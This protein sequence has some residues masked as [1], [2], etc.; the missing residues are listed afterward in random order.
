MKLHLP[1]LA[2]ALLTVSFATAGEAKPTGDLAILPKGAT[3]DELW[4]E[5]DFTE[6]VAAGPDGMIYFSDI[7]FD[8][9]PG[10]VMKLDPATGKVTVHSADSGKSNG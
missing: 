8:E 7:P 4:N 3:L 9:R 1:T 6:G 10:R 5:G 2:V